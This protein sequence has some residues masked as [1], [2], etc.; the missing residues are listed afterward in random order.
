MGFLVTF[1]EP[2]CSWTAGTGTE[3]LMRLAE[4]DYIE[5]VSLCHDAMDQLAAVRSSA[6][7][8]LPLRSVS[9]SQN[10][11]SFDICLYQGSW[12]W[13]A[14]TVQT[15]QILP[16]A[17]SDGVSLRGLCMLHFKAHIFDTLPTPVS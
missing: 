14:T 9:A 10:M 16:Y 15:L 11:P 4:V 2:P 1:H 5:H 12:L 13:L 8:F 3:L 17:Y 6:G 7:L